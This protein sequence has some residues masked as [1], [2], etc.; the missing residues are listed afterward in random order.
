MTD[1]PAPTTTPDT[2]NRR[3]FAAYGDTNAPCGETVPR[4]VWANA[5]GGEYADG[6]FTTR[7]ER[8][9]CRECKVRMGLAALP[10]PAPEDQEAEARQFARTC[11]GDARIV[12]GIAFRAGWDAALAAR[13]AP[14]VNA[15]MVEAGARAWH[16]EDATEPRA[17]DALSD[18][19]RGWY[20]DTTRKSLAAALGVPAPAVEGREG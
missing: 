8:T 3:H 4:S 12:G 5:P 14:T 1:N 16:A 13:P 9:T 7:R 18:D 19:E 11:V 17:W 2:S 15:E 10:A 20:I 6:R